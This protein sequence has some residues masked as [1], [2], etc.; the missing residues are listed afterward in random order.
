[1]ERRTFVQQGNRWALKE[2][3]GKIIKR[4]G[5][6]DA[7]PLLSVLVV[8]E[9]NRYGLINKNGEWA[10]PCSYVFVDQRFRRRHDD[11]RPYDVLLLT[12]QEGK[13]WLADKNGIIVTSRG[14]DCIGTSR[15]DTDRYS[16]DDSNGF[17]ELADEQPDPSASSEQPICFSGLFD[18]E[19]IREVIPP[20][21]SPGA[22]D[23]DEIYGIYSS[24]IPIRHNDNGVMR[25]KLI[26]ADGNDL[27]PFDEGFSAMGIPPEKNSKEY[28]FPAQKDGKWGYINIYGVEKIPFQ[29]DYAEPF[30]DGYAVVGAADSTQMSY[31]FAIIGHHNELIVPYIFCSNPD[32]RIDQGKLFA[33]G[34]DY[35]GEQLEVVVDS[36][37]LKYFRC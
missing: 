11:T 22:P 1:M 36:I 18:L 14:Y 13:S 6:I 26:D 25:C 21:F 32:F 9:N 37:N 23:I 8:K 4:F 30:R 34:K 3:S 10:V 15:Y 17:I 7:Y 20:D 5:T 35:K 16:S 33:T 28:L 29:Y 2:A 24:G 27:I 31:R 12:D 19:H